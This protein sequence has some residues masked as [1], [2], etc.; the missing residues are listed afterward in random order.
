[1]SPKKKII[2]TSIAIVLLLCI[3]LCFK[4]NLIEYISQNSGF[5]ISLLTLFYVVTTFYQLKV[6]EYQLKSKS[7]PFPYI[8]N[9]TLDVEPPRFFYS[10][11]SDEYSYH[12]RYFINGIINN[13]TDEPAISLYMSSKININEEKLLSYEDELDILP[14]KTKS[15]KISLMICEDRSG[16][17]FNALRDNSRIVLEIKLLYKSISGA[18]FMQTNSYGIYLEENDEETIKNWHTKISSFPVQYKEQLIDL[19]QIQ[20]GTQEWDNLFEKIKNEAG[21]SVSKDFLHLKCHNLNYLT[22]IPINEKKYREEQLVDN[23]RVKMW[24]K[25]NVDFSRCNS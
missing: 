18:C 6:M 2:I 14:G 9:I 8:E 20:R 11:P 5:F 13:I 4:I 19:R 23:Y 17:L 7:H 3:L 12:T 21:E 15:D 1:M 16:K 22:Y 10:P 24:F 25:D